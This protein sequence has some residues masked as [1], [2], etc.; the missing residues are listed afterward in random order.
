VGHTTYDKRLE[1]NLKFPKRAYAS[2]F[3]TSENWDDTVG[4]LIIDQN[5][6]KL[7]EIDITRLS[8]KLQRMFSGLILKA[9]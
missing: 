9:K 3:Q 2:I 4:R 5:F 6:I 8:M 7:R 1:G